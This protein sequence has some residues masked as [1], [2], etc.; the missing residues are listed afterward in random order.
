[1]PGP[2]EALDLGRHES[3][4]TRDAKRVGQIDDPLARLSV[5]EIEDARRPELNN[6]QQR[7]TN[8]LDL[9]ETR[10]IENR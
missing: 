3:Q 4:P 9:I 2:V 10:A 6:F 8:C 7:S 5:D 1:M